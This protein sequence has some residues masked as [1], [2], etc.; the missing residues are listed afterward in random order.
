MRMKNRSKTARKT[1]RLQEEAEEAPR[2]RR[3]LKL[4]R[5]GCG[6]CS[7]EG[8]DAAGELALDFHRAGWAIGPSPFCRFCR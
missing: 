6:S 4:G 1:R 8:R 5:S 2:S 7:G 3:R